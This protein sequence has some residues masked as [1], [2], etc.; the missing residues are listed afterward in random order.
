M[1]KILKLVTVFTMLLALTG[2]MKIRYDVVIKDEKTVE[3]KLTFLIENEQIDEEL[4]D[5][6]L[7]EQFKASDAGITTAKAVHET[8]DGKDYSG[9]ESDLPKEASEEIIK[10]IEV[11]DD[12]MTFTLTNDSL[13]ANQETYKDVTAEQVKAM[14][15]DMTYTITMPGKIESTEIGKIDGNVV[16]ITI[17]DLIAFKGDSKIVA[18]LSSGGNNTMMY[19]GIAAALLVIVGVVYV[20]MKRKKA[21]NNEILTDDIVTANVD[22]TG[23]MPSEETVETNNDEEISTE[24][25]DEEEKTAE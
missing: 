20:M 21:D 17:E 14:G 25:K 15:F 4:T 12:K 11:K 5:E 24:S 2:C 19:V 10:N 1:K 18:D 22:G 3:G 7:V 16:T 9:V 13:D 23:E 8:I 6:E